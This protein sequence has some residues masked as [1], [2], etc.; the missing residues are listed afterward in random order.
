MNLSMKKQWG[1]FQLMNILQKQLCA[2]T[3]TNSTK[4]NK[5]LR[6]YPKYRL[7]RIGF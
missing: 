5:Q 6:D 2:L 7:D 4:E 1:K 3:D